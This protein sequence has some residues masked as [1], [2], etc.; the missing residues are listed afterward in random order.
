MKTIL[1][2][3]LGLLL[4]AGCGSDPGEPDGPAAPAAQ[5][6]P[7]EGAGVRTRTESYRGVE[8]DVPASWGWGAA[9]RGES[10]DRGVMWCTDGQVHLPSGEVAPAKAP[11]V[12]RPAMFSD[13]CGDVDPAHPATPEAPYVWFGVPLDAGT[14]TVGAWTIETRDVDGVTVTVASRDDA[15]RAAI[16]G[17]ARQLGTDARDSNGCPVRPQQAG[18]LSREGLGT[19]HGMAVCVY[20]PLFRQPSLLFAS[21]RVDAPDARAFTKAAHAHQRAL[22]PN[23][24]PRTREASD[25]LL[26]VVDSD[27]DHGAP[28]AHQH[29]Q[30]A[31]EVA[32]GV[33]VDPHGTTQPLT[34][35]L[36]RPWAV[37]I[38]KAYVGAPLDRPGVQEYFQVPMG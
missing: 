29:P 17:S 16:L 4:V 33:L 27:D 31:V 28:G 23:T 2:A 22:D 7:S 25:S 6:T 26:L 8:I 9:P 1:G 12:G 19:V 15:E 35:A 3:L 34:R 18:G 20:R 38:V 36:V 10:T 24:C 5:G 21:A 13:V 11:Y 32:C 37:P 14:R 30:F